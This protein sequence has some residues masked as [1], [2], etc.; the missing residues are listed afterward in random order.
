MSP[1]VHPLNVLGT[2]LGQYVFDRALTAGLKV[3]WEERLAAACQPE[4]EAAAIDGT[5]FAR[6]LQD[7]EPIRLLASGTD[8]ARGDLSRLIIR[9]FGV[10]EADLAHEL[11]DACL[12]HF[13]SELQTE[14]AL[15]VL[16]ARIAALADRLTP[17]PLEVVSE[18]NPDI[19]EAN[20]R[21]EQVRLEL[22]MTRYMQ[23]LSVNDT[24][25]PPLK[26]EL[27]DVTQQSRSLMPPHAL[28]A[29]TNVSSKHLRVP[30]AFIR[31]CV[32]TPLLD[33]HHALME[34]IAE[35]Y[36]YSVDLDPVYRD[37]QLLERTKQ[38]VLAPSE[39]NQL[40][41]D[42][43]SSAEGWIYTLCAE[44]VYHEIGEPHQVHRERTT[45]FH[46]YFRYHSSDG[47]KDL[48]ALIRK[49]EGMS[50]HET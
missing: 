41:I 13:L 20:L 25:Q 28:V 30:A 32:L 34:G 16:G 6:W 44:V 42:F 35:T 18:G 45:P 4:L 19:E 7:G 8:D 46:L 36:S 37:Y 47:L 12:A 22:L 10:P 15:A 48:I 40:D 3:S 5:V 17:V 24:V 38:I 23:R 39:T 21:Q 50:R 1:D 33:P 29:I 11:A 26:L 9:H 31:T 49:K 14:D 2:F 27:L 43:Q